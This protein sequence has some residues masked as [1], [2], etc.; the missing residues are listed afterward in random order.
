MMD[1][2]VKLWNKLEI[3][4]LVISSL[5]L[6]I[7]LLG[8]AGFRKYVVSFR[9]A[10][11]TAITWRGPLALMFHWFLW[12]VY[13]MAD[14]VA[15]VA[16]AYLP[17]SED[18]ASPQSKTHHLLMFWA[19][20]F[21]LHLGGQDTIT[22]LSIEDNDLWSRQ[23]LTMLSQVA[24]AIYNY[25]T[26]NLQI[27]ALWPPAALMFAVA[28]FK[29]GERIWCLQ[30]AS[31]SGLRSSM[32]IE[33]AGPNYAK[34]MERYMLS[35]AEVKNK[36]KI[37]KHKGDMESQQTEESE[38]RKFH[39]YDEI[40]CKAYEFFP[41][42]KRLFVDLNLNNSDREGLQMYFEGLGYSDA[43]K[44]IEIEL[45]WMYDIFHS[46]C[47]VIYAFKHYGWVSRA[48][49][50]VITTAALCLFAM[51]DHTGYGWFETTLTYVL[52]GGAVG[53]EFLALVFMLLSLWTYAAMK[54]SGSCSGLSDYH[55]SIQKILRPQRKPRWSDK[56]AQYSLITYS[57]EDQPCWLKHIMKWVG[58]KETWDHYRYATYVTVNEG[59]KNLVFQELKNNMKDIMNTA[60]DRGFTSH[61]GQW[62]I[63]R[64]GYD[65]IFGWSVEVDFD[66][67]IMLWHIATDLLFF[68]HE[69]PM[70]TSEEQEWE[71]EREISQHISNYMM[72]LLIE[73]PFMMPDSTWQISFGQTCAEMRNFFQAK[74]DMKK[75][76][77]VRMI[78]DVNTDYDPGLINGDPSKLVAFNGCKLAHNLKE[79]FITRENRE[80]DWNQMWRF[81]SVVWVEML[82]YAA[83]N[84]KG[85]L[86]AKQLSKG[87][88]L[89]TV[90]WLLMANF[91]MGERSRKDKGKAVTS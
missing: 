14:Y 22:G 78:L 4:V 5:S 74:G 73:R 47:S 56:M 60:P 12:F 32:I 3:R 70:S 69:K 55:F 25:S 38:E 10:Q 81:I 84:C 75:N 91:G 53:L 1:S 49:T 15:M 67:S 63:Q 65:Q 43:Y 9:F 52:L 27:G 39:K 29:Y 88:E 42:Y 40:V 76:D 31:M 6:Q 26:S 77:A 16:L 83:S 30:R 13:L 24:L 8:L 19:P 37:E 21:L 33:P 48:I 46:K 18:K 90:V 34:F 82:C 59:L 86:H 68:D 71:P 64:K 72:F 11:T 51:S 62:V 17:Q 7:L 20:F 36:L 79:K 35:K 44:L 66:E 58:F 80:Q 89:L 28:I 61:R 2:L 85:Q 54:K 50:I 45:S 23:L 87:G 41:R 57:L